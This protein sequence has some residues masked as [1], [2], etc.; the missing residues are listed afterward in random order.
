MLNKLLIAAGTNLIE[1]GSIALV[2]GKVLSAV[3]LAASIGSLGMAGAGK[4]LVKV[5]T[6]K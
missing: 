2:G 1:K 3:A 5:A 4:V 6:K